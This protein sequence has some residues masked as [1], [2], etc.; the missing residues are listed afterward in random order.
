MENTK[1]TQKMI[2]EIAGVSRSMVSLVVNNSTKP[3]HKETRERILSIVE[4]YG[5]KVNP[6][7]L[8]LRSGK[9]RFVNIVVSKD[10]GYQVQRMVEHLEERL[11]GNGYLVLL[12][13]IDPHAED[14]PSTLRAFMSFDFAGTLVLDH[15]FCGYDQN[16]PLTLA[17]QINRYENVI[18]L[19]KLPM[20]Q[21]H[22]SVPIDYGHGVREAVNHL[23]ASGRRRIRLAVNDLD[24][25]PTRGR[26]E[27]FRR[28]LADVGL[29]FH[30]EHCWNADE[31]G[32][33][34]ATEEYRIPR[35]AR[36]YEDLVVNGRADAII[37][38]NDFWAA[39]LIKYL[40]KQKVSVPGDVA[41]VGYENI[42]PLCFASNPELSSIC[43]NPDQLAD[44]MIGVLLSGIDREEPAER[45]PVKTSFV[46]RESA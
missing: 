30:K 44:A 25:G 27:G 33:S 45:E 16:A 39:P 29:K 37:A 24:N 12:S 40:Q 20:R 4:R 14:A 31:F 6:L 26:L 17:R 46:A 10:S 32:L 9:S 28:G 41:V 35:S 13:R 21:K 22:N 23:Y 7:A 8:Q 19:N 1:V 3:I 38:N 11:R 18:F 15:L 42:T 2:A 5:Y 36:I 43:M 34:Y